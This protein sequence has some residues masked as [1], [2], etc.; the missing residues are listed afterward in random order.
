MTDAGAHETLARIIDREAGKLDKLSQAKPEEPLDNGQLERLE[1]LARCLK[2]LR[3]PV[4][5]SKS[6]EPDEPDGHL[7]APGSAAEVAELLKHA[8]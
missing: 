5:G 1:S 3:A 7:P 2:A 8:K 6:G 4:R